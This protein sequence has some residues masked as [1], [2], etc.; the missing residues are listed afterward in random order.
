MKY[1]HELLEK[2]VNY[3]SDK[4]ECSFEG[5]FIPD[6]ENFQKAFREEVKNIETYLTRQSMSVKNELTFKMLIHQYQAIIVSC[7]DKISA[8]QKEENIPHPKTAFD[9]TIEELKKIF[10]F[11]RNRFGNFFNCD[12]KMP[13]I[14]LGEARQKIKLKYKL[15]EKHLLREGINKEIIQL[16][17][18][19]IEN[20]LNEG[21]NKKVS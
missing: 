11:I 15:F 8:R 9:F 4:P 6:Y 19:L 17:N 3:I 18:Y 7:L 2:L 14:Y 21:L 16:L 20:F 5:F 12:E 1:S 13:D 10:S